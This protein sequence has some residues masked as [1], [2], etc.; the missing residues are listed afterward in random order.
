MPTLKSGR[1][2]AASKINL[3]DRVGAA[4]TPQVCASLAAFR[5]AVAPPEDLLPLWPVVRFDPSQGPPPCGA[6][7][8]AGYTAADVLAARVP[9]WSAAEVAEVAELRDCL[10]CDPSPAVWIRL[11]PDE[12]QR[13]IREVLIWN[14]ECVTDAPAP[15]ARH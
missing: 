15:G 13:V 3:L 2:V 9:D 8:H 7:F 14:S 4:A 11:H 1:V 12:V 6:P 10:H 5:A